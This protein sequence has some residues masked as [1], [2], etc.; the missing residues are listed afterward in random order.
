MKLPALNGTIEDY[1]LHRSPFYFKFVK[2]KGDGESHASFVVSLDHLQHVLDSPK[3]KGPKGGVRVSFDSLDGVYLRETD[4]LGL[5]RSGYIGTH[6]IE[7][8]ALKPIIQAVAEGKRALVLA[9]QKAIKEGDQ[10]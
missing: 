5:I 10:Q 8:E 7:T 2:R 3:S 9:W 4:L 1:R 6:R